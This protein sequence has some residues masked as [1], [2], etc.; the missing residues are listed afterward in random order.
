MQFFLCYNEKSLRL[1][2]QLFS[3]EPLL[4]FDQNKFSPNN[5]THPVDQVTVHFLIILEEF[6]N[7][8]YFVSFNTSREYHVF[9]ILQ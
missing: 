5:I 2:F 1:S 8:I 7:T 3:M 6:S 4:S 9:Q